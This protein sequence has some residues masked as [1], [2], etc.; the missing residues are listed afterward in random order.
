MISVVSGI[1]GATA[2]NRSIQ[3]GPL[4]TMS[5]CRSELRH[6]LMSTRGAASVR[7]CAATISTWSAAG[8]HRT[9][10]H[11]WHAASHRHT[12]LTRNAFRASDHFGFA[13]L[14]ASRVRDFTCASLLSHRAGCVR[15]LPRDAFCNH[16]ASCV[17]NTASNA[18]FSVS[19]RRVRDLACAGLVSHRA[20]CVRYLLLAGLSHD[21]TRCVWNFLDGLNRNLSAD[22]IRYLLVADFWNHAC[23][24]DCLLNHLWNPLAAANRASGTL[25]TDFLAAAGVT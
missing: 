23:A 16:A 5:M 21:R 11:T 7:S 17:R 15:N 13:N 14:T 3:T 18:L 24:G 8:G 22:R 9:A 10:N 1:L 20:G 25:H 6:C 19:T 2:G 4:T 12:N